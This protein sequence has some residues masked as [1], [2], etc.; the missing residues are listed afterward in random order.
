MVCSVFER[1]LSKG[2][3]L[4]KP[5]KLTGLLQGHPSLWFSPQAGLG[6]DPEASSH[7]DSFSHMKVVPGG[8][9]EGPLVKRETDCLVNWRASM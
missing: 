7:E 9:T 4:V 2:P 8:K 5:R 1:P 3:G 6:E